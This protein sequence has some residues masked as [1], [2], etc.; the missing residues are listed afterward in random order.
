MHDPGSNNIIAGIPRGFLS[1]SF[2]VSVHLYVHT[3]LLY[4]RLQI[5][6]LCL[7][8]CGHAGFWV[9]G[10]WRGFLLGNCDEPVIGCV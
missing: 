2:F 1:L 6:V 4:M 10:S 7:W 9:G 5:L 8:R 3:F